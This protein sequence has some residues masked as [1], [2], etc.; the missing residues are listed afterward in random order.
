MCCVMLCMKLLLK[1]LNYESKIMMTIGEKKVNSQ[2]RPT[3]LDGIIL[4][5]KL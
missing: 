5:S 1:G 3:K 4:C 2:L